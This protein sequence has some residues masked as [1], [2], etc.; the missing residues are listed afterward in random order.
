MRT[1]E[2]HWLEVGKNQRESGS[3]E[4]RI[5]LSCNGRDQRPN[6]RARG[7]LPS[8]PVPPGVVFLLGFCGR[9]LPLISLVYRL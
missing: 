7:P 1:S 4:L 6:F 9:A 5:T 2:L 3:L 8:G